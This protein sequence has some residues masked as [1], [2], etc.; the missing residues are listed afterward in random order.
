[1]ARVPI[2]V[3]TDLDPA[4][5]EHDTALGAQS[6]GW[7]WLSERGPNSSAATVSAGDL[8]PNASELGGSVWSCLLRLSLVDV[9]DLLSQVE[10]SLL[11]A[12]DAVDLEKRILV[13]RHILVSRVVDNLA[14]HVK[15]G[16]RR[17]KQS[18]SQSI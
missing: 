10:R 1:M 12:L 5:I 4:R 16:E 14:L 6:L 18:G 11:L 3:G 2:G 9:S 13:T 17:R 15:S 8:A 7:K